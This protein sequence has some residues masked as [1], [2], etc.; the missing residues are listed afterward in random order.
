MQNHT[1][2]QCFR[3]S[4]TLSYIVNCI[5]SEGKRENVSLRRDEEEEEKS[6]KINEEKRDEEKS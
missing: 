5:K 3:L 6:Y 1:K 4:R 2:L